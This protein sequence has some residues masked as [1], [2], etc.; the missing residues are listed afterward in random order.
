MFNNELIEAKE[1]N[2]DA[3]EHHAE[4]ATLHREEASFDDEL[5]IEAIENMRQA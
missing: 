1:S 5:I 2:E 3:C 4:I